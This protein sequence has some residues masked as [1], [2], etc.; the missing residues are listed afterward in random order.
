MFPSVR[1]TTSDMSPTVVPDFTRQSLWSD[2]ASG[3]ALPFRAVPLL[4]ERRLLRLSAISAAVT[5]A[6]LL[7]VAWG[8]WRGSRALAEWLAGGPGT[9]NAVASATLTAVAW[10]VF[11]A[12]GALT[13]PNLVLAPLQDPLSEATEERCRGG[14]LS[15]APAAGLLRATAVSLGH[16]LLRLAIVAAGLVVLLPLNF[17]P[18]VG[19][20]AW[21][22]GSTLWSAFWLAVEQLSNPMARHLR[23][24]GEVVTSLRRRP[25]IAL[26][27]GGVLSIILWVPVVNFFLMPVA[28]VAGTLLFCGLEG[29]A[30][31]APPAV[32]LS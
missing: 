21:L 24:F 17:I 10:V 7:G 15:R 18:G 31:S 27:F 12:V 9:W 6:T 16:T 2:L 25:G 13:V 30:S 19:S 20:A 4:L 14:A 26:G 22:V 28:V 3:A 8:A 23:P 29:R 32:A 5:A 11:F 1:L